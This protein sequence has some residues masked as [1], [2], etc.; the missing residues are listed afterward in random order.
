MVTTLDVI[1]VAR[2]RPAQG[3][4][5]ERAKVQASGWISK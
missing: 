5:V 4:E 3:L 1:V 2:A